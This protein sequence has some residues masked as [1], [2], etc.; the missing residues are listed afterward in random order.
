MHQAFPFMDV[1]KITFL[2]FQS[3]V[4]LANLGDVIDEYEK[5]FHQDIDTMVKRYRGVWH[6][7]MLA[8]YPW[9]LISEASV[10]EYKCKLAA[11]QF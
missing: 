1:I 10:I 4:F 9:I 8:D 3:G 11:V 2:A 6:T 5:R 7:S